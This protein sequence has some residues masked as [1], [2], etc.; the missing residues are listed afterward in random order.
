[1]GHFLS[2]FNYWHIFK[3]FDFLFLGALLAFYPLFYLYI[4]S[5]FGVSFIKANNLVHFI[6]AI[7]IIIVMGFLS[8]LAPFEYYKDY[9]S[10][11]LHPNNEVKHPITSYLLGVYKAARYLHLLQILFYNYIILT[12]LWKANKGLNNL[13]SNLDAFQIRSFYT[14]IISFLILM[15]IPGFYVTLLGRVPFQQNIWL[16]FIVCSLFTVLYLILS[17]IGFMQKPVVHV[18]EISFK[19]EITTIS[20]QQQE[21]QHL[22]EV[23]QTYFNTE[24]P[25]LNP[26]LN[27]WDI[28]K[29]IGTNRSYVSK[30]I[31][32]NIGLN[33]NDYINLYRIKEAKKLLESNK[34][35]SIQRV[36]DLAGF[37]S[38]NTFIRTFKKFEHCTPLKY[39]AKFN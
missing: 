10:T 2:F 26:H 3:Y 38:V 25:W 36:A 35:Y 20:F 4:K 30:I 21:L 24:K 13:F 17:T 37:G 27:I 14:V 23:L 1:M 28:A 22:E 9:L 33:F 32:E 8:Y 34:E 19:K 29:A 16:L 12:F 7:T 15:S 39:K 31:N 5:T 6:P 18:E 11:T